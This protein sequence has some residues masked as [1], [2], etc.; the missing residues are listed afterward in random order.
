MLSNDDPNLDSFDQAMGLM[1]ELKKEIPNLPEKE[2][3]K[4]AA[5]V[6]MIFQKVLTIGEEESEE[7]KEEDEKA[8]YGK[9]PSED[10]DEPKEKNE[11]QKEEVESK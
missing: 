4:Y 7:D 11:N 5:D 6:A 1:I 2:R 10:E 3:H 9:L 8:G